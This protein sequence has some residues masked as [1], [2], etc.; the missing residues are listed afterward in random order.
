ME[1]S[2]SGIVSSLM[3]E[4]CKDAGF[5]P[6]FQ[7]VP[8]LKTQLFYLEAGS[9][10]AASNPYSEVY[11]HPN[12]VHIPLPQLPDVSFCVA[13]CQEITNPAVRLFLELVEDFSI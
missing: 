2:E 10:V 5:F 6:K 12:L 11:N 8:D 13:F 9:G 7:F 1:D 3:R 4:S